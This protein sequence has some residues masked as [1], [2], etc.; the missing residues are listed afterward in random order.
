MAVYR[1][2][3]KSG[4][5]F[6]EVMVQRKGLWFSKGNEIWWKKA[7]GR[8]TIEKLINVHWRFKRPIAMF[9]CCH[10]LIGYQD[11]V[12]LCLGFLGD[13]KRQK[14][15]WI[16][17]LIIFNFIFWDCKC[18]HT[19]MVSVNTFPQ[20]TIWIVVG[21]SQTPNIRKAVCQDHI[22]VRYA[23]SNHCFI[24]SPGQLMCVDDKYQT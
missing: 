5:E 17:Y 23:D 18:W 15:S 4:E 6:R 9:C 11:I 8:Q 2:S 1:T 22:S 21:G 16:F 19:T 24:V 7:H 12:N 14:L 3:S 20:I 13:W 10:R